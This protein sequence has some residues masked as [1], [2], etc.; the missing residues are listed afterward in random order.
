MNGI[1]ESLQ[2]LE[3]QMSP[4]ACIT[5]DVDRR[6]LE[7]MRHLLD[8]FELSSARKEHIFGCYVLLQA[9]FRKHKKLTIE[10][11]SLTKDILDGDYLQS[12]YYEYAFQHGERDLVN[13]LAPVLKQI[14]I[15]KIQGKSTERILLQ[16]MEKFL[17]KTDQQVTYEVS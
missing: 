6:L 15:R 1:R 11:P 12:F 13:F 4:Q 3:K 8:S 17:T 14:Q 16:R 2:K 9:A 10:N 7:E 5:L